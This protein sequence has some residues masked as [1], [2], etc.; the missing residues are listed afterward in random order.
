MKVIV[1]GTKEECQ[2]YLESDILPSKNYVLIKK[3]YFKKQYRDDP[4]GNKYRLYV[5]VATLLKNW[6]YTT[7]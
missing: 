5:D 4:T 7:V 2:A 1:I 3:P 6:T